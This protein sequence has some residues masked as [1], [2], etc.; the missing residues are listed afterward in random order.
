VAL[1]NGF[2]M[3]SEKQTKLGPG[4]H[5]GML[6]RRVQFLEKKIAADPSHPNATYHQ[7]EI[8]A[9]VWAFEQIAIAQPNLFQHGVPEVQ[10]QAEEL[11]RHFTY[12]KAAGGGR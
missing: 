10:K 3:Q 11:R 6:R 1:R 7:N 5:L 2:F 9:L 12:G 8:A 4:Q